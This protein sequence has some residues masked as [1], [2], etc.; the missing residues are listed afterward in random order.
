MIDFESRLDLLFSS[1]RQHP[2][3]PL[4]TLSFIFFAHSGRQGIAMDRLAL[5]AMNG[6]ASSSIVDLINLASHMPDIEEDDTSSDEEDQTDIPVVLPPTR[7]SFMRAD[8]IPRLNRTVSGQSIPQ[9]PKVTPPSPADDA[10]G[11]GNGEAVEGGKNPGIRIETNN[12][13]GGGTGLEGRG[14]R[15]TLSEQRDSL[16]R[17][18]LEL[19]DGVSENVR[20]NLGMGQEEGA[21]KEVVL[22]EEE[23]SRKL[24]VLQ[25][26]FGGWCDDSERFVDQIPGQFYCCSL[27][28]FEY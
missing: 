14:R 27:F 23:M 5:P 16:V 28:S 25:D 15:E 13:N 6:T 9:L 7:P 18:E 12:L 20:L 1:F 19:F 24:K 10:G 26:E 3:I 4:L 17:E 11:N 8:T 2:K 22:T 21:T